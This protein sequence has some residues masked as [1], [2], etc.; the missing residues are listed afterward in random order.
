MTCMV[1]ST[2]RDQLRSFAFRMPQAHED[3]PWGESVAKVN[4]K[5]FVFFGLPESPA[6]M[7][8]KL[9]D[10]H[11]QAIS[12]PGVEP[13]GYGLGK[14][15]WLGVPLRG[16]TAPIGVLRDWIEESY[17]LVAPKQLSGRLDALRADTRVRTP[18]SGGRRVARGTQKRKTGSSTARPAR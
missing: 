13:M 8:V 18:R 12:F 5:V 3:H 6:F 14:S 7:Y 1:A 17:R 10:S 2:L 11:G 9:G 4:K 15:G 16:K